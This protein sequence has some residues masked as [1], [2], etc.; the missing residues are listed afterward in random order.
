MMKKT[1]ATKEGDTE[2]AETFKSNPDLNETTK[3]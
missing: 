3:L 1:L 2:G